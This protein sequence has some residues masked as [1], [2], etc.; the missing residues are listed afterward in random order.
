[1]KFVKMFGIIVT[2]IGIL[3]TSYNAYSVHKEYINQENMLEI[4][5]VLV[6]TKENEDSSFVGIYAAEIKENDV[7]FKSKPVVNE[8]AL[9][10]IMTFYVNPNNYSDYKTDLK[11]FN[12]V[13]AALK[14]AVIIAVGFAIWIVAFTKDRSQKNL[15]KKMTFID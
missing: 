3:L 15:K 13:G 11:S 2:I 7:T 6:D 5:A 14:Y 9:S 10:N 8:K 4:S 12:F 1:M